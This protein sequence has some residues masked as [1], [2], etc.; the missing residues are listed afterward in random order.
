MIPLTKLAGDLLSL[1][2]SYGA[3]SDYARMARVSRLLNKISAMP[4]SSPSVVCVRSLSDTRMAVPFFRICPVTLDG[5]ECK[6]N[7]GHIQTLCNGMSRENAIASQ[8]SASSLRYL[9]MSVNEPVDLSPLAVMRHLLAFTLIN[10]VH[11]LSVLPSLSSVTSLN[12]QACVLTDLPE[13]APM[14]SHLCI[15]D[16]LVSVPTLSNTRSSS[17]SASSSSSLSCGCEPGWSKLYMYPL[18]SLT[19]ATH[20]P[21]DA[22]WRSLATLSSLVSLTI[23]HLVVMFGVSFPGLTGLRCRCS[24]PSVLLLNMSQL[25]SLDLSHTRMTLQAIN[26]LSAASRLTALHLH[27]CGLLNYSMSELCSLKLPLLTSLT[28]SRNN[29]NNFLELASFAG[30]LTK[31]DVQLCALGTDVSTFLPPLPLLRILHMPPHFNLAQLPLLFPQLV[32]CSMP[33]LQLTDSLSR[34][35]A[36]PLHTISLKDV[37]SLSMCHLRTICTWSSLKQIRLPF[38]DR[39]ITREHLALIVSLPQQV[40]RPDVSASRHDRQVAKLLEAM[41]ADDCIMF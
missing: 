5:S 41:I 28:I 27:D 24:T 19:L 4:S 32:E 14:L 34:L 36:L 18:Q 26:S 12:V 9:T 37:Y 15:R 16:L 33:Y 13:F 23:G 39:P 17:S 11:C 7:S 1:I 22:E 40:P 6:W 29:V 31:L 3:S 10:S 38:I 2:Y 25:Q 21:S 8:A 20:S 30:S 35:S